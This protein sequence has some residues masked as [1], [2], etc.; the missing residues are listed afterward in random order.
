MRVCG[1]SSLGAIRS[2]ASRYNRQLSNRRQSRA[3]QVVRK[4]GLNLCTVSRRW[5]IELC[6]YRP[7]WHQ[8]GQGFPH[9]LKA[10]QSAAG[11]YIGPSSHQPVSQSTRHIP[12]PPRLFTSE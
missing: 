2:A 6:G 9:L 1:G 11:S 4:F 10:R 12:E 8:P 7:S 3:V 5:K